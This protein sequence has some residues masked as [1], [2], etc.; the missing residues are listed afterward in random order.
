[1]RVGP[2][3]IT[4]FIGAVGMVYR[5]HDTHL[6]RIVALKL[7]PV[8]LAR[9]PHRLRRFEEEARTASALNHPAIVTIDESG[10]IGS[11][12]C[13]SMELVAIFNVCLPIL[14]TGMKNS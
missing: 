7:L 1:M 13:I 8:D 5:T 6:N 11:H 2:Y 3:E 12:P 4:G 14:R 10:Q 9:D